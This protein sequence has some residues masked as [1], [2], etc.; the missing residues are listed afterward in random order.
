MIILICPLLSIC[1]LPRILPE[2]WKVIHIWEHRVPIEWEGL[3]N[4][5]GSLVVLE[6]NDKNQMTN[7]LGGGHAID[8]N[9]DGV[10]EI[11]VPFSLTC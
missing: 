1:T 7:I 2:N 11:K 10:L 9:R 3:R 6:P 4:I 8:D 5:D